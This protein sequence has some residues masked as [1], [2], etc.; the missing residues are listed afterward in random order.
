VGRSSKTSSGWRG[1][2]PYAIR[3]STPRAR[4]AERRSP[5][6]ERLTSGRGGRT[7]RE[8]SMLRARTGERLSARHRDGSDPCSWSVR[9]A[10]RTPLTRLLLR[11]AT[12]DVSALQARTVERQ[13][14]QRGCE[15][16]AAHDLSSSKVGRRRCPPLFGVSDHHLCSGKCVPSCLWLERAPTL[17]WTVRNGAASVGNERAFPM[18]RWLS[19]ETRGS[20]AALHS[21]GVDTRVGIS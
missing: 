13:P 9:V 11:E 12:R 14:P 3:G 7:R 6:F 21:G 16:R 1:S 8:G 5:K 15:T 20:L 18:R 4:P 17:C 19:F 2:G 10:A